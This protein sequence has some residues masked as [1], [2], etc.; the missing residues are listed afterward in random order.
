[1]ARV[2][3]RRR[4]RGM[5]NTPTPITRCSVTIP[6]AEGT[7]D[8]SAHQVNWDGGSTTK[9]NYFLS[10]EHLTLVSSAARACLNS[11]II[12]VSNSVEKLGED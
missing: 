1:M 7:E 5:R 12:Q 3:K 11:F 4:K 6:I 2:L 8:H 10:N 9:S